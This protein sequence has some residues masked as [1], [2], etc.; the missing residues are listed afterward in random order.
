MGQRVMV[1]V[2]GPTFRAVNLGVSS[3]T[4]ANEAERCLQRR[5][6]DVDTRGVVRARLV[7]TVGHLY[8][9]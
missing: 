9:G 6:V 4:L 5:G 2:H 1:I 7:V 8:E 3:L